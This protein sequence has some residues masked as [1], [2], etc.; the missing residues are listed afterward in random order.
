[1]GNIGCLFEGSEGSLVTNYTRHEVWSRGKRIDDFPRPAP[2][3]PD[4]PGH[5]REFVDA[6]RTRNLETTCNVRYGHHLSK[7]GLL[8]NI[9]YRT[10][11]RLGWDDEHERIP[12]DPLANGYLR[13][14]FRR[15]WGLRLQRRPAALT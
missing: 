6:I 1:M 11:H 10:G 5:L 15:P 2:S 14:Q 13:R 3:I 9:S 12:G 8:A 7:F 4:S